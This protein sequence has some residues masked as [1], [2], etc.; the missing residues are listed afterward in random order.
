MLPASRY[1]LFFPADGRM[2]LPKVGVLSTRL[3]LAVSKLVRQVQ[4]HI[5]KNNRN[6]AE[7]T[8]HACPTKR[9]F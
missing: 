8:I 3:Y 6:K 1:K 9:I 7:S 4:K 2:F 5:D